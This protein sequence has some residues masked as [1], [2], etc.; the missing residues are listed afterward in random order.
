MAKKKLRTKEAQEIKDQDYIWITK[1]FLD[2]PAVMKVLAKQ[3]LRVVRLTDVTVTREALIKVIANTGK[4][5]GNEVPAFV[6]QILKGV[7]IG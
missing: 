5:A 4:I 3:G 2:K 1:E 6:E 7:V